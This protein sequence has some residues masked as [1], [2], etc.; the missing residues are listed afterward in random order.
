MKIEKKKE[1]EIEIAKN[2]L[3]K[4]NEKKDFMKHFIENYE[5]KY[6]RRIICMAL[7]G[8]FNRRTSNELFLIKIKNEKDYNDLKKL[9]QYA[10][11]TYYIFH[12]KTHQ[13]GF[14]YQYIGQ[15]I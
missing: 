14:I 4:I 3:K 1:K 13:T 8:F 10:T 7:E 6:D 12:Q 15:F 9:M 2:E 5:T 11:R